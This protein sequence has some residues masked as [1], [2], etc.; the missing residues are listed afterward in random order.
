MMPKMSGYEFLLRVRENPQWLHIPFI[1]LTAKGEK[2][3]EYE[4]FRRGVDEYITKPYDSDDMLR[5]VEKQLD[6]YFHNQNLVAQSFDDLK[7]SIINLIS[8]EFRTPL[9][10]VSEHSDELAKALQ[11][12]NTDSDL[13][14]SLRG[15]QDNSL[16]LTRLIEDFISLAELKTGEAWTAHSLKAYPTANLGGMLFETSQTLRQHE[17]LKGWQLDMN[18]LTDMPKV[19]AD[20]ATLQEAIERLILIGVQQSEPSAR[21]KEVLLS[22]YNLK[23]G[24]VEI[25]MTFSAELSDETIGKFTEILANDE[26]D[27]LKAPEYGPSLYIAKGYTLLHNGKLLFSKGKQAGFHFAIQLPVYPD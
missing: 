3:D 19:Q 7:R 17:A 1:F 22:L 11:N 13:K 8:P 10:S 2:Q 6:K 27:L 20:S 25:V 4:G 14:H 23:S 21:I 15:I 26:P 9:T 24:H 5:F 18:T 16:R 12:A